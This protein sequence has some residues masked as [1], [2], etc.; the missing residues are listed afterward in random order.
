MVINMNKERE[1]FW[2]IRSENYDKLYWTKDLSF[3]DLIL[4][5]ADLHED[6]LVLDAGCGT[7]AIANA[8]KS[9]VK[10]VIGVDISD[11][12][13]QKGTWEGISMVK[14]DLSD[15][16]FADNIFD[17]IT[18]RLV[19]HHI[20][21]DLDRAF[22]RCYDL[23]KHSGKLIVAEGVPPVD[24]DDVVDWYTQMFKHKEERR[25]F[26][27]GE[28]AYFMKKNSFVDI[29]QQEHYMENF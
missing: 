1:Y 3:I 19:F 18:A 24:D 15:H 7:G 9:H 10:H 8:I 13:L 4:K 25:T 21:D 29:H 14:C 26:K 5:M 22:I 23:L 12:M 6:Q 11:A 28:I 27:F 16:L 20:L 17:R 2:K